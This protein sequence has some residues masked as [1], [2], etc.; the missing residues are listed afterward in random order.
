MPKA[1]AYRLTWSGERG[2]YELSES[3]REQALPVLP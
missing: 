3:H 2:V 1:A